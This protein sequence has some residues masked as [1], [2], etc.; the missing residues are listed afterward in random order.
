[1]AVLTASRVIFNW[2]VTDCFA[3]AP[4]VVTHLVLK[5]VR[6]ESYRTKSYRT[7]SHRARVQSA[8]GIATMASTSTLLIHKSAMEPPPGIT[9]DFE[10]RFLGLQPLYIVLIPLYLAIATVIAWARLLAKGLDR[11]IQIED[12]ACRCPLTGSSGLTL[13]RCSFPCLG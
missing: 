10:T 9:A 8:S 1:M 5:S 7:K 11:K 2:P 4:H 3:P 12:C 13:R 6:T